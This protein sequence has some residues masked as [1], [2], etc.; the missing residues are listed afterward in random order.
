ML[1]KAA[2][3]CGVDPRAVT[4]S[5]VALDGLR[6]PEGGRMPVVRPLLA[7]NAD[8]SVAPASTAKLVTTLA[9]L[10]L[11][12]ADWKWRTGFYAKARPD[13]EGR[14]N[15]IWLRGGGDPTLVAEKFGLL[16]ERMAQMGVRRIEGDLTVDRSYFDL[17]EGDPSAFDGRGSRPYNQ[18]PDAAVAGYRSLSFE[19]VPDESSGTARIISMP[20]LSGLEVP[21]T[22]RLSRGAC[23]DWKSTIGYRLEHLSDGRLAARFE[24][25]LPLSCGPKTF[26]VVSLS[27]NEYLERLFRWYWERDGRTWTGH[28]AEGRVPEG[29]LKLAERESD[30]LPVVTTLVNKWS[31]NLIARHIFLTLGT[32]RNAP[33]EADSGSRTAGGAFAPMERP[34]PGV[35]TDDARAVLAGWLAEKGVPDGAV[36]IDNSSAFRMDEDVPLVVPEVNPGDVSWHNGVIANPNCTTIQMVVAL[37]AIEQLSHIKT[38]HV[39]T[40]QAASGAGAAAMDELYEQYRQVLANE[41]VTVEKFAYQLAFNLIPQ[42]DVFTENGYTKEEMKMF[43][44]TRKI[45]HSDIQVSAMCVRVPA[46]RSHSESIWV[47]TERPISPEEAREAFA[48]GEGL[49]LMDNPEK[50]EYPM[51][52]FLAGKDPVYVGRI[53]KD[54]ANE[55][56]LTF[57]IVGDQIKKGAALN[58][59]QIAEYLIKVGNVK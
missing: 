8:R 10:E 36:M 30:A 38:V 25:S 35:D 58:A 33:D 53:R 6:M 32:L 21:S 14:V 28:V 27:Q 24:G 47:E 34:R 54:L 12:G 19:F 1:R 15:G 42:I 31:N 3:D 17:P 13:A 50:K 37:K 7:V 41:P 55:N 4:V 29:A 40:Y 18:L 44:E 43:N 16:V 57:W 48:K 56:G 22:I 2:A 51:P 52:L 49:V 23:G 59:V 5:V 11:L 39:S 20:P 46:L 45:M 26:S 9:G